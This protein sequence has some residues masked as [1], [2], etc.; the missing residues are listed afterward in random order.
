MGLQFL[1]CCFNEVLAHIEVFL[2][3]ATSHGVDSFRVL[4]KFF[5]CV[6]TVNLPVIEYESHSMKRGHTITI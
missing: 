1:T 2:T 6:K 3:C 5:Y 4:R